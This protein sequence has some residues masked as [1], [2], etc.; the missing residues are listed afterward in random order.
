M[1]NGGEIDNGDEWGCTALHAAS[2][3]GHDDVV[4]VL[5]AGGAKID[6]EDNDGETPLFKAALKGH[7]SVVEQLLA[8]GAQPDVRTVTGAT[9]LMFFHCTPALT[10]YAIRRIRN[11]MQDEA[12]RFWMTFSGDCCF[13]DWYCDEMDGRSIE[14]AQGYLLGKKILCEQCCDRI[15]A[16]IARDGADAWC[17]GW[18]QDYDIF[19][20]AL[21]GLARPR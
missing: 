19:E 14:R 17:R 8:R 6:M 9:A 10:D 2:N 21:G 12:Q 16:D 13:C 20:N 15:L 1:G 5:L 11:F 18:G 7:A 4:K 3:K